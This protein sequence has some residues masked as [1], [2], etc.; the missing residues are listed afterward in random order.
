VFSE[1]H[2]VIFLLHPTLVSRPSKYGIETTLGINCL[3]S[4]RR[5][6]DVPVSVILK[7]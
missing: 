4:M 1:R 3:A 2:A 7:Y 5:R 6:S